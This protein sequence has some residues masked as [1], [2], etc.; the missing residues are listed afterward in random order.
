MQFRDRPA[1]EL[2]RAA[3]PRRAVGV[4]DVAQ[5][6]VFRRRPILEVHPDLDCRIGHDHQ[7]A[8]GA[9]RRIEDR[10]ECRLHQVGMCP[11]D[12]LAAPR[13]DVT[14]REALA[15]YMAGDVAGTDKD[16]FLS[17]HVALP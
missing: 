10:P 5:K 17:Q 15:A 11:A 12:S 16:Q 6:E 1:E 3:L 4:A 9:E 13:L 2:A 8:G 7:V 14:G